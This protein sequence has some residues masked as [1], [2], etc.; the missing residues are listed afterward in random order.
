MPDSPAIVRIPWAGVEGHPNDT[1]D[2]QTQLQGLPRDTPYLRIDD[3]A[4][5]G[6]EWDLLGSHFIA[7]E[8]LELESGF[9]EHLNDNI[10]LHWPLQRLQ[11]SSA[12]S[13]V[14]QT[15]F[16]LEGRVSHLSLLL[17]CGLRFVGPTS[18]ELQKQHREDIKR[19]DKEAEYIKV[20]E[21]TPEERKVEIHY[22]PTL[23]ADYMNEH[24]CDPDAKNDSK[25]GPPTGPTNMETL[26]VFEN[27][28]IDT[29]CRM[30][31]ALPHIV[32]TLQTLR[33][34]STSGLDFQYLTEEHFRD[35]LPTLDNLKIFNLT[36]GEVFEDPSYLPTF[37]KVLP[38]NLSTLY[39]R[40]PTSLCRSEHW[41]DWLRVFESETF[42]PHLRQLA[43]VL[44][45]HYKAKSSESWGNKAEKAPDE[46][47]RQ[48]REACD[49]LCDIARKRGINIVDMPA[50]HES[51]SSLFEPVDSRW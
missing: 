2:V 41:A 6:D 45:L 43:F 3:D 40:G 24:Y 32:S 34:R 21:G 29:F 27:D 12:V 23:V 7:V 35:L 33:I 11:L 38:P 19:G 49:H 31:L 39:F 1:P 28:A 50:E 9:N 20:Y 46:V 5:S 37:Y 22:L 48:A 36:V 42:L 51:Q 8:N 26:E 44:D 13:E 15:P 10:P 30:T 16:I 4:P 17:T 14:I 18:D 25:N 47:L